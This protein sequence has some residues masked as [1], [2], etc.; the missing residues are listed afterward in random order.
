[1]TTHY[2]YTVWR[3]DEPMYVGCTNNVRR[4]IQEHERRGGGIMRDA[5]CVSWETYPDRETALHVEAGK[6]VALRP[7]R[8]IRH[9]PGGP[10]PLRSECVEAW[11]EG[12]KCAHQEAA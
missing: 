7:R 9:H 5:T 12:R 11:T 3:D 1:M 6:I 2:V 8:N 4:R 10:L